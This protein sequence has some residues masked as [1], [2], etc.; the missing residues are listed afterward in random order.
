MGARISTHPTAKHNPVQRVPIASDKLSRLHVPGNI[1][2]TQQSAATA[3]RTHH[4]VL[5]RSHTTIIIITIST[6]HICVDASFVANVAA[7]AIVGTRCARHGAAIL[8]RAAPSWVSG[9]GGSA[10]GPGA[11]PA[12]LPAVGNRS[13]PSLVL[14][15]SIVSTDITTT[16]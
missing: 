2:Q 6:I 9:D 8:A 16:V 14:V 1:F 13:A 10:S 15:I 11:R 5:G 3:V 7:V 4:H 12:D